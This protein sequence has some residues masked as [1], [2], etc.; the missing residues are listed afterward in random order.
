M[1]VFK[2]NG[3]WFIDYRVNG[4]RRQEK[5]GTSKELAKKVLDKRKVEIAEGRFLDCSGPGSLDSGLSV[6]T[7]PDPVESH[8]RRAPATG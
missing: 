5:I 1:G 2:E 4:Q 6:F 3:N 8:A 7:P